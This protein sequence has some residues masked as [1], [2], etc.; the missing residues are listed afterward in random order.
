MRPPRVACIDACRG[1]AVLGMLA[2]NAVNVFMRRIPWPLAHNQ[3]NSLRAFDLPAPVFQFLVGVSLV[4]FL[5]SRTARGRS[6]GQARMDAVRRFVLLILLGMLLDCVGAL[7]FDLRW[8]VLQTLGLG[9]IVGVFFADGSD[10]LIAAVAIGLLGPFS[11][12]LNGEVHG[13]PAAALAFVPLTLGGVLL[14]RAA[15]TTDPA[16][17]LAR[18][19]LVVGIGSGLLAAALYAAGIP[20]NKVLGTSSF[21]TLATSVAALLIAL[22]ATLDGRGF[23]Y[24]PWLLTLGEHAL[25]AWVLQYVLLYYPAWLVFPAWR[26]MAFAPGLVAIVTSTTVLSQLTVILGRRGIRISL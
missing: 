22:T 13:S 26:R 14:G 11:G 23:R 10:E 16:R 18:R 6:A 8:G 25:T 9:G 21:V 24:P 7:H 15:S 4:L 2:A 1:L 12:A 17:T 20:F 19:G 3:G 5:R